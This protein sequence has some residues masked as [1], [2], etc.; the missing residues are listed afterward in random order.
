VKATERL[1]THIE[2]HYDSV[3]AFCRA[4]G[5]DTSELSKLLRGERGT[6]MSV[7]MAVR[8]EKACKGKRPEVPLKL[9]AEE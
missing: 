7:R 4:H 6:N 9:W 5:F 8:I 3:N 2:R 1:K